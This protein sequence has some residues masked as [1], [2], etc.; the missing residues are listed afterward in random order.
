MNYLFSLEISSVPALFSHQ[1]PSK[2][3]RKVLSFIFV[4]TV[5]FSKWPIIYAT[6]S[7]LCDFH[8]LF[9]ITVSILLNLGTLPCLVMISFH[10]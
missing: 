4:P 5:F 9:H 6:I 2:K 8:F 3:K 10:T 7:L 1:T